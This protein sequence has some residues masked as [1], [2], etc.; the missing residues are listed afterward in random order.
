MMKYICLILITLLAV[1]VMSANRVD[2]IKG[3]TNTDDAS[4]QNT[5]LGTDNFGAAAY[6]RCNSDGAS[7]KVAL[8]RL[9]NI[10]WAT[11]PTGYRV[12]SIMLEMIFDSISISTNRGDSISICVRDWQEGALSGTPSLAGAKE[13]TWLKY[14]GD[15][16]IV[17]FVWATA[18]ARSA[19]TNDRTASF[20]VDSV[21]TTDVAGDKASWMLRDTAQCRQLRENASGFQGGFRIGTAGSGQHR[22]YSSEAASANQPIFVVYST[23]PETGTN[24]RI[25]AGTLGM[26]LRA[27]KVGKRLKPDYGY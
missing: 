20:D 1:P 10:G 16:D 25:A 23:L 27:G 26:R 2:T 8:V 3:A 18:G 21:F 7:G 9:N 5:G 12:D 4:I 6:L 15:E 11:V 19:P 22:Y 14:D 24:Q 17:D 13:V